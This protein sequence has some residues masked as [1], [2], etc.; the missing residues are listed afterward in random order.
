MDRG[1]EVREGEVRKY[2]Y[3]IEQGDVVPCGAVRLSDVVADSFTWGR[4]LPDDIKPRMTAPAKWT[5]SLGTFAP[6][7]SR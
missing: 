5:G 7:N 3:V 6:D 4:W 2:D 1:C